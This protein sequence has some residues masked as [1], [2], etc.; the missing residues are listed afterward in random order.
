VSAI[1]EPWPNGL[2]VDIGDAEVWFHQNCFRVFTPDKVLRVPYQVTP[3]P[4]IALALCQ[5]QGLSRKMLDD[6]EPREAQALYVSNTPTQK[7]LF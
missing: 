6:M 5:E 2:G 3:S 7:E 1:S 4:H